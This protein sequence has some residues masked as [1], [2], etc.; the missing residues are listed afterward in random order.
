MEKFQPNSPEQWTYWGMHPDLAPSWIGEELMERLKASVRPIALYRIEYWRK[1]EGIKRELLL[2]ARDRGAALDKLRNYTA[3]WPV[4]F[5]GLIS[6]GRVEGSEEREIELLPA[7]ASTGQ[8]AKGPIKGN[9]RRS[10]YEK[11][12]YKGKRKYETR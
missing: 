8:G 4:P 7:G 9:K 11:R 10:S 12:T 2:W 3:S 5:G 6:C 1:G